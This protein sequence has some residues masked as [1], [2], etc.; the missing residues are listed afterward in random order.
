MLSDDAI[1]DTVPQKL[2]PLIMS[3]VVATMSQ[4]TLQQL[5]LLENMAELT[6]QC[7]M[8]HKLSQRYWG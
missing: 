3:G 4:R 2:Q 6:A 5:R 7:V 8:A 1:K